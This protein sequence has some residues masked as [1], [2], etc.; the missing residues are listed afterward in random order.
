MLKLRSRFVRALFA[1]AA[2]VIPQAVSAQLPAAL[3]YKESVA[4]GHTT[5]ADGTYVVS[6]INKRITIENGR[7]YVVDPWTTA[8]VFTVMPGMVTL[9]NFRQ[10]G[11]DTFEADDLPMMGKVS[12]N[13]QPNGT[14][15]G[16]VRGAMG[17]AKY[18]LVPTAY[19]GA[20]DPSGGGV[21]GD[22][23]TPTVQQDRIYRLYV[24]GSTCEGTKVT[25]KNF[26]GVYSV[27]L[28]DP[29]G[30]RMRSKNRNYAVKCTKKGPRS[31][32]YKFYE[33]GP[34]ALTI[35]VPADGRD[36]SNLVLS[37]SNKRGRNFERNAQY[38]GSLAA[39]VNNPNALKVGQSIDEVVPVYGSDV[40]LMTRVT[41]KRVQ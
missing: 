1:S 18:A 19:A 37:V 25:R 9:Q 34:G 33:G 28:V 39:S 5:S 31:Q 24:S 2:L 23:G 13:R 22:R 38:G 40:R 41:L 16:V 17:E 32:N 3:P 21:D 4:Q 10:T 14:L 12:F 7:A 36:V 29:N 30:N 15:Q 8:M 6:T 20:P 26:G 35:R 27:S 11:P